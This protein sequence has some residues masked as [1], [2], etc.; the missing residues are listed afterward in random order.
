MALLIT[1]SMGHVG[2]EI[3]RQ[4]VARGHRVVAQYRGTFRQADAEEIGPKVTWQKADLADGAAVAAFA[5]EHALDG[6]I[7][8]AAVPNESVA[9]PDP[10]GAVKSNVGAVANLLD[11]AR[12]AGWR[13]FI[14]VSTGSVF[15]NAT[16]TSVPILEDRPPF[17]SNIYSTT[18]LCGEMLTAMYRSQ[19]GLS[20][21][22][23]RIS[24]VYGP[25]FVPRVRD[26]PRGP[27]PWFLRCAL[28][29]A[30]VN[31][32]SGGDF[33]ASYTHVA[34]VAR[35]LLAAYEATSLN[36]DV[37]HLGWGRNFSTTE[38]VEAVQAAVPGARIS[39]GPGTA[40]Y[41]DH[42]R[43]RG[44]LAG[45][46]LQS[47]TGWTPKLGLKSGIAQFADWM[48]SHRSAWQ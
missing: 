29:G 9:R 13:R 4:A 40:P 38:V 15:Q 37:Y 11:E 7:H 14:Y 1:G 48:R 28:S 19:F 23:V 5:R 24:W 22:S 17:V 43:M 6:I 2:L 42:T 31:D 21:A 12:R 20:A 30:P 46:R 36:H 33:L 25:P 47:D 3:V 34:D 16:D 39:V 10:L 27:I 26:N 45:T 8:T 41:T 35:G 18:K 32:A 44:P